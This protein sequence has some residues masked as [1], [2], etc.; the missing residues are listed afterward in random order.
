MEAIDVL[1]ASRNAPFGQ[2]FDELT[3]TSDH[4]TTAGGTSVLAGTD[5]ELKKDALCSLT[6][7][8][9]SSSRNDVAMP[10]TTSSSGDEFTDDTAVDKISSICKQL[11]YEEDVFFETI[12]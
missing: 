6:E 3:A 2:P 10:T 11:G 4:M 7:T 12:R 9:S 8:P 5:T 1:L